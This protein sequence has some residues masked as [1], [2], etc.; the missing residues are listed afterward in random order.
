MYG[1]NMQLFRANNV[2]IASDRLQYDFVKKHE[3]MESGQSE[4]Q[5]LITIS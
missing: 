5:I 2:D 3:I 1:R 4:D